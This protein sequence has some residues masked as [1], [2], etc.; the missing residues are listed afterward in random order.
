MDGSPS[1][2]SRS[3]LLLFCSTM[4]LQQQQDLQHDCSPLLLLLAGSSPFTPPAALQD[5]AGKWNR[6]GGRLAWDKS[7]ICNNNPQFGGTGHHKQTED[8]VAAPNVDHSQ[9]RVKDD[10]KGWLKY[11][12][13]NVGFDGWRFD[14]VKGYGELGCLLPRVGSNVLPGA[15]LVLACAACGDAQTLRGGP[16]LGHCQSYCEQGPA[17][18]RACLCDQVVTCMGCA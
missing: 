1:S 15:R 10:I 5:D 13:T 11:L 3:I 14:F 12:R 16:M 7:V 9:Q 4:T 18:C 17:G 8:Y 6:F 2:C